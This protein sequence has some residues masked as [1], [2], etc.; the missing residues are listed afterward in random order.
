MNFN[1]FVWRNTYRNK[2]LYLA[3]FLSTLVTVMAFFTFSVFA[4]HPALEAKNLGTAV[5]T[6]MMAASGI[7]YVFSFFFVMYSMDI[8][9]QTRKKEFG[10][11]MMQGMSPKQLKKMIFQENL[12]IGF[13]ATVCGIIVGTGFSQ[14]ILTASEAMLNITLEAYFPTESILLTF[15]SFMILFLLISMFIQFKLPKFTLQELLKS[16]KFG[17][18][19][20]KASSRKSL[21]GVLLIII[22]YV[23]AVSVPAA[24]VPVVMIPV[25]I[26]VIIGTKFLFDQFTIFFVQ[27]CKG[28][29]KLFWKKTNLLVFS[30]L[31][32]RMKD[33]ARAFFLVAIISTVGFTAIASLYNFKE[34]SLGIFDAIPYEFSYMPYDYSGA[35]AQ[36]A[37]DIFSTEF[38]QILS[39]HNV[40]AESMIFEWLKNDDFVIV[41]ESIYN[42]LAKILNQDTVNVEGQSVVVALASDEKSNEKIG[43]SVNINQ[44]SLSVSEKITSKVVENYHPTVIVSDTVYQELSTSFTP[45]IM[46]IWE[47]QNASE[48]QI[49]AIAQEFASD[50]NF[51]SKTATIRIILDIYTPILFVGLFIGVVFFVSAGSFLYF[52]LFS[53]MNIDIQKFRMISKIGLTRKELKK[54]ISQQVGILFFT[55]IIVAF[56]HGIVALTAMNHMFS[57]GI[58]LID[59]QVLGVLLLIQI[60]YYGVCRW[61]YYR[62]VEKE[63]L[64]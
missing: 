54:M 20:I 30:D 55:P 36:E 12:V 53:D 38:E 56:I 41:S 34:R 59:L 42:Q 60:I 35:K 39:E 26:L 7:I 52:R 5:T 49:I 16:D 28:R 31:G 46:K 14:V 2:H 22:G 37:I 11:F 27:K 13:F 1:Q 63:V 18:G 33:N 62:K 58:Q 15:V 21:M 6:G 25:I 32:F 17:K 29:K 9:L 43:T 23:I 19:E 47:P 4:F 40:Q 51:S 44:T 50:N 10:T 57:Q 61:F 64:S 8:F 24:M 48:E 3:Y 45:H